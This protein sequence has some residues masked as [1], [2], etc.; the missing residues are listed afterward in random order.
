MVKLIMTNVE[1]VGVNDPIFHYL[2]YL[3]DEVF[4]SIDDYVTMA[5]EQTTE[6][7]TP[8]KH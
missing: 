2:S 4:H 8:C 5:S 3:E 6:I 1:V 7:L